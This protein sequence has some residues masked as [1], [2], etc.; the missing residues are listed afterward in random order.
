MNYVFI[1]YLIVQQRCLLLNN[2]FLLIFHN[3]KVIF[4]STNLTNSDLKATKETLTSESIQLSAA[5]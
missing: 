4:F 5:V 2:F 1:I 3:S